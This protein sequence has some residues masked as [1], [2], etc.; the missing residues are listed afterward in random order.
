MI[1][2]HAIY[3]GYTAMIAGMVTS[4]HC[5]AMCGPLACAFTPQRAEEGGR[6]AAL[7]AYHAGKLAAY[8]IVGA[9]AGAL[10]GVALRGLRES[11]LAYLPWVLVVFFVL[12]AFRLDRFI[13]KPAFAGRAYRA[14]TARFMRLRKPVAAGAIGLATPLLPCGPLYVIFGL[15]LLSGSAL[16]GAEFAVGFGLG[17]LPLLWLAQTQFMRAQGRLGGRA[18]G[19]LQRGVALAAALIVAWRL[20][21]TLGVETGGAGWLC[22]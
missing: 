2:P 3:N 7:A 8:G 21:G 11:W 16:R 14:A 22:F 15:A 12:V 18:L 1:D 10:G 19:R 17:T 5:V 4:V 13:P 20:R 6:Q 9:L